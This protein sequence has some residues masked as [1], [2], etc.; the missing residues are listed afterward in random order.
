MR[1]GERTSA[2]SA[3]VSVAAFA[4]A[5]APSAP[6]GSSIRGF[7]FG[8]HD[9]AQGGREERG[10]GGGFF[11]R[12]DVGKSRIGKYMM[13][14]ASGRESEDP[15]ASGTLR[16]DVRESPSGLARTELVLGYR[17]TWSNI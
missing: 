10:E 12:M 4:L 14:D 5:L 16:R 6:R 7:P 8:E 17:N 3:G 1:K 11:A 15:D 9:V 2:A 13:G